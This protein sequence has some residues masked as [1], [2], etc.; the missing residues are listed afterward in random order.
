MHAW[1][2]PV[3]EVLKHTSFLP[4]RRLWHRQ[5]ARRGA[6]ATHKRKENKWKIE[7]QELWNVT[8]VSF[9]RRTDPSCGP[10]LACSKHKVG[11]ISL[12]TDVYVWGKSVLQN[13]CVSQRFCIVW[14]FNGK[15][16]LVLIRGV[17][18]IAFCH[19]AF[20][21]PFHKNDVP[22]SVSVQNACHK[23]FLACAQQ[24]KEK[25][26]YSHFLGNYAVIFCC[27]H[28]IVSK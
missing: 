21:H 4:D 12:D 28:V 5:F 6:A 2:Q 1:S 23:T 19:A 10:L 16:S 11:Q 15:Q 20:L 9:Y 24:E 22:L 27:S 7:Q 18:N 17:S 14:A 26:L 8:F 13:I 3:K 25:L